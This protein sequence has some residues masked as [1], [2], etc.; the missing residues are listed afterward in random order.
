M[1]DVLLKEG[2]KKNF[3][4]VPGRDSH[5]RK[6]YE[7]RKSESGG[8]GGTSPNILKKAYPLRYVLLKNFGNVSIFAE[9]LPTS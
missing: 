2:S 5:V 1:K 9:M 4:D 8:T 3:F 7:A 6:I